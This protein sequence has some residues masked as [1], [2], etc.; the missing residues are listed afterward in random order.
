MKSS[1]AWKSP[2][3][4][5][6]VLAAGLGTRMRPLTTAL[7]KPLLPFWGRPLLF[8]LL[9]RLQR[10]G[11]REV[12]INLHHQP[13]VIRAAVAAERF[14]RLDIAYSHEPVILGTGG[15]LVRARG[16]LDQPF[17]MVNADIAFDL[18]PAPLLARHARGRP[19]A[20][21]WLHGSRGPRTVEMRRGL[22]TEFRSQRPATAGTYTY[23]C[24]YH[25]G[26]EGAVI[27]E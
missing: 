3:R 22:I 24:A 4:K 8:I 13:D 17:W 15:A 18:D 16:F 20:T 26:M 19:L 10:W 21:C 25:E 7:P 23:Y 5:A 9:D 1:N 11:V 14:R 27:V 12:L 6:F 2:P